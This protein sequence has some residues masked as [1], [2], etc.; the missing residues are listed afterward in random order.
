MF[1]LSR[2]LSLVLAALALAVLLLGGL[3]LRSCRQARQQA[4]QSR[5]DKGQ[6]K[7]LSDSA[8]DAIAVQ[9]AASAR[10]RAN[11]DLTRSN[12]EDIRNAKG[13]D[14][15]VDPAVRDAAL[16]SLCRRAAYRDGE[17]CRLLRADP[18]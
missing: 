15:A 7:A 2:T 18:R 12:E 9:G 11:D 10:E 8:K 13:A 4:A 17:R 6:N 14:A 16:R 3:Q 5:V 1:G